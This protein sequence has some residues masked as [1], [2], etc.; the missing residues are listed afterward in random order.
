[1]TQ[2]EH[3]PTEAFFFFLKNNAG[4]SYFGL[5]CAAY[6]PIYITNHDELKLSYL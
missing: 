1:M 3:A 6:K 2:A 5:P 4:H